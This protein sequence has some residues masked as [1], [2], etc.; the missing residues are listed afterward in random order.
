MLACWLA[1]W[2]RGSPVAQEPFGAPRVQWR[3]RVLRVGGP[4]AVETLSL[5]AGRMPQHICRLAKRSTES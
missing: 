1:R 2:G 5:D 3:M 4:Q